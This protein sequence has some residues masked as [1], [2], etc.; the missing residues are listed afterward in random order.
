MALIPRRLTQ[1]VD[2]CWD[3]E[4]GAVVEVEQQ[5]SS[6]TAGEGGMPSDGFTCSSSGGGPA[7]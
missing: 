3:I 6:V 7:A 5:L 4:G 2:G 1:E